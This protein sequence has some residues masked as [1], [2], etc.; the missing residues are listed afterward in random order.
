MFSHPQDQDIHRDR[1][2]NTPGI[3]P[4]LATKTTKVDA[5]EKDIFDKLPSVPLVIEGDKAKA[6]EG[7]KTVTPPFSTT[8]EKDADPL[9]SH[10][11]LVRSSMYIV[12]ADEDLFE[13]VGLPML[14][15]FQPFNELVPVPEYR[16]KDLVRCKGCGSFPVPDSSLPVDRFKCSL[17][18]FVN[19]I[20]TDSPSFSSHTVDYIVDGKQALSQRTWYSGESLPR[21]SSVLLPSCRKWKEPCLVFGLDMSVTSKGSPGYAAY[22][23]GMKDILKSR[24]FSLFYKRFSVVIFG[25]SPCVISDSEIG[26]SI[27]VLEN[28]ESK[29]EGSQESVQGICSPLFIDTENLTEERVDELVGIIENLS[30]GQTDMFAGLVAAMQL[31]SYTGGGKLLLWLGSGRYT[32]SSGQTILQTVIDCGLSV[33]IFT[34]EKNELENVTMLSYGTGG[35]VQREGIQASLSD[36][37]MKNS[38]FRCSVRVVGSNGLKR[39]SIYSNGSFENISNVFFPEMSSSTAFSASFSVDEFLKEGV[40]VFVQCIV[41]Y[42]DL[43][44]DYRTRVINL[45]LKAS[46]LIQQIFI[47]LSFDAM[48]CGL[49][50]YICSEP[51]NMLENIRKAERALVT[52]LVLYKRACAKDTS[53]TQLVLPDPLKLLPVL[54]QSV[55]KYPKIQLSL[56]CR[57]E[58]AGEIMPL[59]VERT[60]RMFYPRLIR[61]SALFTVS[62]VEEL[63]GERLTMRH[64]CEEDSYLLDTGSKVVLWFGRGAVDFMDE[65]MS[66]EVVTE[67]ISRLREIYGAPMKVFQMIQGH[68]DAD[69]IGYMVED[70]M[71]GYPKYQEYLTS[72]H[73]KIVKH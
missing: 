13:L 32:L 23:D 33:H 50:K 71:G 34:S 47:G 11:D 49:C 53:L 73:G 27:S 52:S 20:M 17:C 31:V 14:V 35:S 5:K 12:P 57:T 25:E 64:L 21:T 45:R 48:F 24:N 9:S 42:V 10:H 38:Y 19:D 16:L 18:G 67:A 2:T 40:P 39:R 66:S 58:M 72:L 7:I 46:R 56:A 44:G 60:F 43:A 36:A 37:I 29:G 3:A 6:K 22:I 54:L 70:Q 51:V 4:P 63:A 65:M 30:T 15:T 1:K 26:F 62:D 68:Q 61:I 28:V 59:S 41:E 55:L 8:H 69:F